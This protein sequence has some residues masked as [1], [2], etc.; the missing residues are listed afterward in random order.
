MTRAP[1]RGGDLTGV[2]LVLASHKHSDHLDPGTLPDLLAASPGAAL[3][4]A[5]GAA[6]PRRGARACRPSGSSGWTP[7]ET[8]E[9]AGFRVRADPLGPRG[10]RHRRARAGIFIWGT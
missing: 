5:R 2:D 3:V 10:A 7:G 1:L 4:A 6:R 8:F 9:R